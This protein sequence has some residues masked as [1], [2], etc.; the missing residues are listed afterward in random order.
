MS[1][2]GNKPS[3]SAPAAEGVDIQQ[4]IRALIDAAGPGV[5]KSAFV[6][7][8]LFDPQLSGVVFDPTEPGGGYLAEQELAQGATYIVLGVGKGVG[9]QEP[10]IAVVPIA[11]P[12]EAAA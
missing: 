1:Y 2:N 8:G 6:A 9:N 4:V 11:T 10:G 5:I 7:A 3:A 12:T